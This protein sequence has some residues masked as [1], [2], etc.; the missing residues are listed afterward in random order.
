MSPKII[1]FAGPSL[2]R[3]RGVLPPGFDLR[4]PAKCGDLLATLRERPAAVLLVDGVFETGPT[5]WHKEILLLIEAGIAVYGAASLG[6][7]RAAELDLYGMI[8]VGAV[9]EAY[10]DGK[11]DRDDAV[12]VSHAPA[13]LGHAPLTL[14]LV[15]AEASIVASG[16]DAAVAQAAI[17]IARAMPFRDRTWDAIFTR[18]A[19]A[20]GED[21][22]ADAA[23]RLRQCAFSQKMRDTDLLIGTVAREIR[24]PEAAAPVP[25]TV[26][27]ERLVRASADLEASRD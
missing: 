9:Y 19:V 11:I 16:L 27:V 12:M 25:R 2:Q 3:E 6:A 24:R 18:L 20:I 5:V 14:A 15:D 4:P 1:L 8:G 26:Y 22:A 10:R 13:E 17:R 23:D 21:S 7:L